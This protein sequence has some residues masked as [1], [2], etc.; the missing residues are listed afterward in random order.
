MAKYFGGVL[1]L[2]CLTKVHTMPYF[3]FME[4]G[5]P[6]YCTR[7]YAYQVNGEH[8]RINTIGFVA[9]YG[10]RALPC[11]SNCKWVVLLMSMYVWEWNSTELKHAH[12][13]PWHVSK[14]ACLSSASCLPHPIHLLHVRVYCHVC[15]SIRCWCSKNR[16]GSMRGSKYKERLQKERESLKPHP[17]S[18][19]SCPLTIKNGVLWASLLGS[20]P[21]VASVKK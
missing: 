20:R 21:G 7:S 13:L 12:S 9:M 19:W 11:G 1:C 2:V 3:Q 14:C 5:V 6:F 4:S 17:L 10:H 15:L 18:H 8:E 16:G